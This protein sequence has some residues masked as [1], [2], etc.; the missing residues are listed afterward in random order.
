[1]SFENNPADNENYQLSEQSGT[2]ADL[3]SE[4]SFASLVG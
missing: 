3:G 2:V 4:I 1:M